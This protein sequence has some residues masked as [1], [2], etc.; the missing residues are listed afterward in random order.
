M[1][2]VILS[3]TPFWKLFCRVAVSDSGRPK[4]LTQSTLDNLIRYFY[5]INY[6]LN[7]NYD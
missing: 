3:N 1:S 6:P 7:N 5:Q 2:E 4:S